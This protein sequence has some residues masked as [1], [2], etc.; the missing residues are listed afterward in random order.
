VLASDWFGVYG[1]STV[2]CSP[3][4]V[5]LPPEL[6]QPMATAKARAA[7]ATGVD[8]ATARGIIEAKKKFQRAL[9]SRRVP[10]NRA[11]GESLTIAGDL[12]PLGGSAQC[13]FP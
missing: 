12:P 6:L 1:V 4:E 8:A 3:D 10:S 2:W 9:D 11:Q 5:S 7:N 13:A